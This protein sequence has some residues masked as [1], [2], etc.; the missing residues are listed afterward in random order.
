MSQWQSSACI[1]CECNCGIRVQSGGEDDRHIVRIRGDEDHPAS[2]GYLCQ[3][4]SGLD[5]YQNG[6]DRIT[7][8][9]RRGQA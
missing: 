2:R 5:Y 6:K 8:P 4:A 7:A 3:K 9:L 1:L